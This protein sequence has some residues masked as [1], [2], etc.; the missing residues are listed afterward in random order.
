MIVKIRDKEFDS[1]KEI[2]SIYLS[3][4]EIQLLKDAPSDFKGKLVC[5]PDNTSEEEL[6]NF[7]NFSEEADI[8]IKTLNS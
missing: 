8:K 4:D 5:A 7:L 2:I 3:K 1:D 6:R